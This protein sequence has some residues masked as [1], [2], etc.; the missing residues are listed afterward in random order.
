MTVE[1]TEA[2]KDAGA[3]VFVLETW[4]I[5]LGISRSDMLKG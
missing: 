4:T 3:G 2:R 1:A 5:F